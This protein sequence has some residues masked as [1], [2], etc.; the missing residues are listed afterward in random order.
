MKL[1]FALLASLYVAIGALLYVFQRSLIY[2]PQ[3]RSNLAGAVVMM[4]VPD[5]QI[6]ISTAGPVDADAIVYFGGNADDVSLSVADLMQQFPNHAIYA[7]HY[8]GYGGSTGT[9]SEKSIISDAFALMKRVESAH[10]KITVI[11]RSLGSGVAVQIA[12]QRPITKLVLVTPYDSIE[13]VAAQI[14]PWLPIRWL[15][16]DKFESWKVAHKITAPTLI[17][18]AQHDQVIPLRNTQKLFEHLPSATTKMQVVGNVD[19]N[20]VVGSVQYQR[21]LKS[22][23]SD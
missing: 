21:L 1:G 14:Y 17:I 12:A 7:M 5:A 22:A 20:S 10:Q 18:A 16:Q 19:H 11:G 23:I 6:E 3:P 9:P 13:H 8:R 4:S 2:F 15:L